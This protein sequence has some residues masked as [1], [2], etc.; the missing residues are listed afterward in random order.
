MAFV[1][2]NLQGPSTSPGLSVSLICPTWSKAWVCIC[3]LRNSPWSNRL[4]DVVVLLFLGVFG[5]SPFHYTPAWVQSRCIYLLHSL[6]LHVLHLRCK[7]T[8]QGDV[9]VSWLRVI[10]VVTIRVNPRLHVGF[11]FAR[12]SSPAV[13]PGFRVSRVWLCA[14]LP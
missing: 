11:M 8:D 1:N 12:R 14:V 6:T 4:Y 2:V 13:F 3:I 10:F 9:C 7:E 5:G